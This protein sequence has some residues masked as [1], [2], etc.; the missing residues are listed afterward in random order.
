MDSGLL[1]RE[2][3][4]ASGKICPKELLGQRPRSKFGYVKNGARYCKKT[5]S[6]SLH[7][8]TIRG[9]KDRDAHD[10]IRYAGT[11]KG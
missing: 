3:S 5:A 6:R 9:F 8:L 2:I 10:L 1:G 4:R 7:R 11:A